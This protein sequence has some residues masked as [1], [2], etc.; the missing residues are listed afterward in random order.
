MGALDG[1]E[2]QKFIELARSVLELFEENTTNQIA[3]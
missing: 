3:E 1:V 2:R